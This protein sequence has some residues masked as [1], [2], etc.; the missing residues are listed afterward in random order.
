MEG[1][2]L[3]QWQIKN[4]IQSNWK[5]LWKDWRRNIPSL[6]RL[7]SV[8]KADAREM[9]F[10]LAARHLTLDVISWS[11]WFLLY[12]Y[13]F[14]LYI[15][16][17]NIFLYYVHTIIIFLFLYFIYL[18]LLCFYFFYFICIPT[19]SIPLIHV[20]LL[21]AIDAFINIQIS[22]KYINVLS[23]STYDSTSRS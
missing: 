21:S 20:Y 4:V 11:D 2:N 15:F 22:Y 17:I 9:T 14:F 19:I 3:E 6:I 18:Q 16:T 13:F 8:R 12:F 23:P 10:Y 1:G 5:N 7:E